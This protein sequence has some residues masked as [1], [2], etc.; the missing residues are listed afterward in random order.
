MFTYFETVSSSTKNLLALESSDLK[1]ALEAFHAEIGGKLIYVHALPG[2]PEDGVLR[3]AFKSKGLCIQKAINYL[4]KDEETGDFCELLSGEGLA[5]IHFSL[6][7]HVDACHYRDRPFVVLIPANSDLLLQTTSMSFPETIIVGDYKLPSDAVVMVRESDKQQ[8]PDYY[9]KNHKVVVFN[10]EVRTIIASDAEHNH[11][12]YELY[13]DLDK[14]MVAVDNVIAELGGA[15]LNMQGSFWLGLKVIDQSGR[16]IN[17][18]EIFKKLF[19]KRPIS[20]GTHEYTRQDS[21]GEQWRDFYTTTSSSLHIIFRGDVGFSIEAYH[22]EKLN[23]WLKELL[24]PANFLQNHLKRNKYNLISL[25]AMDFIFDHF[26]E[27]KLAREYISCHVKKHLSELEKSGLFNVDHGLFQADLLEAKTIDE[28]A[29]MICDYDYLKNQE[30]GKTFDLITS[31][32]MMSHLV[33]HLLPMHPMEARNFLVTYFQKSSFVAALSLDERSDMLQKLQNMYVLL[34][35]NCPYVSEQMLNRYAPIL[36]EMLDQEFRID[37]SQEDGEWCLAV[38]MHV[39]SWNLTEPE[40]NEMTDALFQSMLQ[41]YFDKA[42]T[43]LAKYTSNAPKVEQVIEPVHNFKDQMQ[44]IV[45]AKSALIF[46]A[47]AVGVISAAPYV[48]EYTQAAYGRYR[49]QLV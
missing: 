14:K 41:H 36:T 24:I 3:S 32:Q 16:N 4:N 39:H 20:F 44:K 27:K 33:D 34:Y 42:V 23:N 8:V 35:S 15:K 43:R 49:N 25:R 30:R 46:S 48:I 19:G 6:N 21:S 11:T 5:T 18:P 28:L 2:L 31:K 45:S 47:M 10:D 1:R 26:R 29:K 12:T 38:L 22:S 17:T 40:E 37:K 13:Y 7:R 9:H